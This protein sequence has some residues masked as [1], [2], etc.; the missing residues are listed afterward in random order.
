MSDT[1][2]AK[3]IQYGTVAQ[4]GAFTPTPATGSQVLY[5]WYD[6][7]AAPS[8]YIWNGSAWVQI[9]AGQSPIP[10]HPFLTLGSI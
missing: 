1:S 6:T 8:T 5:I 9:N 10:Y 4:R 2:I 3:I 7:D